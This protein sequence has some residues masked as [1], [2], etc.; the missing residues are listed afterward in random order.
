MNKRHNDRK[1]NNKNTIVII[2]EI[3]A[4]NYYKRERDVITR[5]QIIMYGIENYNNLIIANLD[6]IQIL[7]LG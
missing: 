1:Q 7:K 2:H 3:Y 5:R 4:R 6:I